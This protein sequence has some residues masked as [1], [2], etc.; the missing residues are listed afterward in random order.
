M[1]DLSRRAVLKA[2]LISGAGG[3][4]IFAKEA[5]AKSKRRRRKKDRDEAPAGSDDESGAVQTVDEDGKG[6]F[7][8]YVPFTQPCPLPPVATPLKGGLSREEDTNVL[9]GDS[10]VLM[11]RPARYGANGERQGPAPPRS[12]LRFDE[13]HNPVPGTGIGPEGLHDVANGIA[14]EY[15]HFPEMVRPDLLEGAEATYGTEQHAV[16]FGVVIESA[17]HRFV[18]NGPEVDVFTYRDV[19]AEAGTGTVPGPTFISKYRQP[20]VLRC[21]NLLTEDR[22]K[23]EWGAQPNDTHHAHETSIH[24]HGG[25]NTAHADGYPDFY[26][27]AGESRD[28]WYT[29]C[30]PQ[31]T[32]PSNLVAPIHGADQP[33]AY[34]PNGTPA[35]DGNFDQAWIPTTLWYHDHA[36]DVTGYNVTRGLAGFYL[37]YD[38]REEYLAEKKVIPEP[39]GNYDIGLAIRDERFNADGTVFYDKLDHNGY[40]GDVFLVNGKVQPFLEVEPRKYR[41]RILGANN[42]RFWEFRLS[43]EKP[44][45]IIGTDSWLLPEAVEA[46]SFE[47][48]SGMRH[49][50]IIDFSEYEVGEEIYLEN[51]MIQTDGRKGKRVDPSRPTKILQFRVVPPD[52]AWDGDDGPAV[53]TG[54]KIRGRDGESLPDGW[55]GQW[56]QIRQEE[57]VQN[58]VFRFDRGAGAWTV[59]NRYFNPRRSDGNPQLGYGAEVWS[60][61]NNA[62]GWWHPVHTHLEGHQVVSLNGEP[63]LPVLGRNDSAGKPERRFNQDLT[64]LHGGEHADVRVKMRSFTGPFVFHCHTVEHEDMRMMGVVDPQFVPNVSDEAYGLVQDGVTLERI[65]ETPPLDGETEIHAAVSGVEFEHDLYLNADGKPDACVMLE[66]NGY[67]YFEAKEDGE[68]LFNVPR[69]NERGVG[70]L[71]KDGEICDFDMG[72]RGNRGRVK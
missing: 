27:M 44:V 19:A 36:M 18:P 15:G 29:N 12:V 16:E 50:V 48:S 25:H 67:L 58:R 40:I 31:E 68:Y 10:Q 64:T 61:A 32:N 57:V 22:Q 23:P 5:D 14:P 56:A 3:L 45:S 1:S 17:K 21:Y 8:G 72:L 35:A 6:L 24:L 71:S 65:D 4:S 39:G 2:G 13:D 54:T 33:G 30:G 53:V 28:Y 51:I 9:A 49:D 62:G 55:S 66:E 43:D 47:M 26:T 37:V 38:K 63:V 52:P 42:A 41:F 60:V 34:A 46:E 69:V 20:A 7:F 70:F 11:P 59:N